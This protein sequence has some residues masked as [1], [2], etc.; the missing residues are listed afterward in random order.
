MVV[1]RLELYTETEDEFD[2]DDIRQAKALLEEL[3]P[4]CSF[5]DW[6][7]PALTLRNPEFLS[8][9]VPTPEGP[10]RPSSGK[11]MEGRHKSVTSVLASFVAWSIVKRLLQSAP[12]LRKGR[13]RT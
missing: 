6:R 10:Q 2:L 1:E 4:L 5:V 13:P 9:S 11:R 7:Q 3:I 12:F 8:D